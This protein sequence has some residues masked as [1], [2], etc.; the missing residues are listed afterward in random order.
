MSQSIISQPKVGDRFLSKGK[1]VFIYELAGINTENIYLAEV[2]ERRHFIFTKEK[3]NQ[4]IQT[5]QLT[6]IA[7]GDK[8]GSQKTDEGHG[9]GPV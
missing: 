6:L 2:N 1:G 9:E 7:E 8:N 3:F 5:K 4:F